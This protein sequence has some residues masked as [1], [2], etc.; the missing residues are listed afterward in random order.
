VLRSHVKEVLRVTGLLPT[1]KRIRNRVYS[2]RYR[3][4][5][6]RYLPEAAGLPVPPPSLNSL[7]TGTED[8]RW[9][10]ESGKYA[11][12]SIIT[13]LERNLIPIDSLHTILD[14]GCGS[15]RV[16]R[17]WRHLKAEVF[18]TDYN[19]ESIEW[20][21]QHLRFAKFSVNQLDPPLPYEDQKFDLIYAL[22]VFTH[23]DESRQVAWMVDLARVLKPNGFLL[24]TTVGACPFHLRRLSPAEQDRFRRGEL[25]V[26]AEGLA[27]TNRCAAYHPPGYVRRHLARDFHVIDHLQG[28]AFGNPYQDVYLFQKD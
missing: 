19:S 22:S 15:G 17:Y 9:Y 5:L 24:I 3:I 18:G 26:S 6:L 8:V 20:C 25:V 13:T 27:G 11:A 16:I 2:T 4:D 10:A 21:Q 23:L 14:F 12:R 28:G 7:V 1:A